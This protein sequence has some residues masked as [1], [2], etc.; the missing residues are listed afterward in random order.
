MTRPILIL[1]L[2]CGGGGAGSGLAKH[3]IVVGIDNKPLCHRYYPSVF[4][5]KDV[6]ELNIEFLRLFDFIWASPPCQEFS[7]VTKRWKKQDPIKYKHPD[8]VDPTRQLLIKAGV[9]WVIEN[10]VGA[11]LRVDLTLCGLMFGLDLYRHRIFECSFPI[12]QPIHPVH[13]GQQPCVIKNVEVTGNVMNFMFFWYFKDLLL[14]FTIMWRSHEIVI[15]MLI[16]LFLVRL[17]HGR[18]PASRSIQPYDT[19][20]R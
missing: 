10:V 9:P 11:P 18:T 13:D 5:C 1:D 12:T 3:G 8:L 16:I 14:V 15:E 19:S 7:Q 6:F 20:I 17:S 4:V 2:F